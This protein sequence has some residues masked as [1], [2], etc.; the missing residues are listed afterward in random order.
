MWSSHAAFSFWYVIGNKGVT[1]ATNLLYNC[2]ISDVM[3]CH[4]VMTT[5]LFHRSASDNVDSQSS[6]RSLRA[7]SRPGNGSMRCR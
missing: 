3:T 5:G 7:C 1:F 6:P 2:W 4:K